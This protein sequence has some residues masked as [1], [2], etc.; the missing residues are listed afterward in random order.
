MA[1]APLAE[2]TVARPLLALT[3]HSSHMPGPRRHQQR[4]RL[5]LL[6]AAGTL[7]LL[8]GSS[9]LY[10]GPSAGLPI[11][12]LAPYYSRPIPP[13]DGNAPPPAHGEG[14]H[15]QPPPPPA[16]RP[17]PLDGDDYSSH[18]SSS[19]SESSDDSEALQTL[20]S[21]SLASFR[22]REPA[23][24]PAARA[25]YTLKTGRLPPKG[26]DGF[27]AFAKERGCLVD[28]YAGVH[29]DFAPF[30]KVEMEVAKQRASEGGRKE[31]LK[32]AGRG[33]FRER[34]RKMEAK[35]RIGYE[36]FYRFSTERRH[37][38]LSLFSHSTPLFPFA[39]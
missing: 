20:A 3:T 34:V 1:Y 13:E 21:A 18:S 15:P 16:G 38:Q 7:V 5:L 31:G 37:R 2:S 26:Y 11:P 23:T 27:F 29:R 30:W 9:Y 24:L 4:A 10:F 14:S 25:L 12:D 28:G 33:W 19:G 35:V 6:A 8:I 36:L 32:S 39:L 17:P 22:S